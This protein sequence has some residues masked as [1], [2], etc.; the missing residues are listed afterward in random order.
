MII[1]GLK[2]KEK[3]WSISNFFLENWLAICLIIM[4][5]F[6]SIVL[7]FFGD[8]NSIC[9]IVCGDGEAKRVF[10][11]RNSFGFLCLYFVLFVMNLGNNKH[12]F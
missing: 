7:I 6:C 5:I 12:C 4:L 10:E 3:G 11:N 1:S 2:I 9:G 8:I